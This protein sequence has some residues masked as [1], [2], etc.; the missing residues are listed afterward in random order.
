MLEHLVFELRA[1]E[2]EHDSLIHYILISNHGIHTHQSKGQK[3][4]RAM[5]DYTPFL[6][7]T[8]NPCFI[9]HQSPQGMKCP[10]HFE[11]PH[12]LQILAFEPQPYPRF[13]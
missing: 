12:L 2:L 1:Q 10:A 8:G 5:R 6:T 11:R 4:T 13:G 3:R 9:V 7:T